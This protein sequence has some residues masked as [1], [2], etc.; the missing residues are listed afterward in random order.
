MRHGFY[1][2]NHCQIF[3]GEASFVDEHRVQIHHGDNT[4]ENL[5]AENIVIACGSLPYHLQ[6]ADFDHAR[7]YDSDSILDLKHEP[8]HVLFTAPASSAASTHPFSRY[9]RQGRFDNTHD[10]LLAFLD[11]EM[12]DALS[13]HFWEN[14][15]VIRH[16]K[17]SKGSMTELR[18]VSF[19]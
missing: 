12:S 17:K 9:E 2:R 7:I 3:T 11:Q 5:S 13:Y 10:R 19:W 15:V 16:N 4:T 1:E 8:Q 6:N 18:C 14:G